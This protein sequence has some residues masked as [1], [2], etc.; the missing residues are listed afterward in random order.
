MLNINDA[1]RILTIVGNDGWDELRKR[2]RE[3]LEKPSENVLRNVATPVDAIRHAQGIIF[4]LTWLDRI[5]EE[6][7]E[8][9][10]QEKGLTSG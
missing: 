2:A 8:T 9:V 3:L 1:K 6:A 7:R 4:A 5:I 10:A